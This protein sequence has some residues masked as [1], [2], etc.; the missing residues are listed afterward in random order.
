[1]PKA[2]AHLYLMFAADFVLCYILV[3]VS[4]P[5][6]YSQ[7]R[8]PLKFAVENNKSDVVALLRSAVADK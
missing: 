1:M 2:G 4:H 5:P 7:G 6:P 3:L 8:T